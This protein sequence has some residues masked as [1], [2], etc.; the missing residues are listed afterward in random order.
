MLNRQK[1]GIV[2]F[3]GGLEAE[4]LRSWHVELLKELRPKQM[5]FA[6]DIPDDLPALE[7]AARLFRLA[8]YGT[9]NNMRC[10]VLIGYP[11]DSFQAAEYR[12]QTI[13]RMGFCPM[14]MLFRN[15]RGD[16]PALEW[17]RF[18]RMWARPAMMYSTKTLT[19][20]ERIAQR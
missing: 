6:F 3:T 1:R 2:Q 19:N 15:E 8:E 16:I 17:R 11:G 5:F 9:R 7:E 20:T 4:R 18:P 13:M 12:L 14:T 10:Y